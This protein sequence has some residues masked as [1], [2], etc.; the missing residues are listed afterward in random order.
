MKQKLQL[1]KAMR[2]DWLMQKKIGGFAIVFFLLF[3]LSGYSQLATESFE[4]G[5]PSS[6]SLFQNSFGTTSWSSSSDGYQGG[7]AAVVNPASENIG[8][9]NT[10]EYY[11]VTPSVAVPANGEIRFFTKQG[12]AS[13]NGTVYQLRL[14]TAS[15]P[16][17]DGFSVVLQTWTEDDLNTISPTEY[18]EKVVVIPS[19]IPV[20]LNVYIAF[21]AVNNQS[22]NDPSGDSWFIDDVRVIE[23]CPSIASYDV[24]FANTTLNSTDVNWVNPSAT[25]FEI[26][27]VP[28]GDAPAQNGTLVS[29]P[30]YSFSSLPPGTS[31]DVYIKSICNSSFSSGW[32]GPFSFKTL[33]L[34]D[35]CDAPVLIPDLSSP[36]VTTDNLN[37][38][39]TNAV[40]LSTPGS[41]CTTL[42]SNY[43]NGGKAF[44]SFTPT[45]TG[46]VKITMTPT[47]EFSYSGLF[48]YEGCANVGVTCVG[49]VA[50]AANAPRIINLEVTAGTNYI[51]LVSSNYD[52]SASV[53]YTLKVE[54]ASCPIPFDVDVSSILQTSAKLS[55]ANI[56]NYATSWE[57]AVQADG[58]GVPSGSGIAA[59]SNTNVSVATTLGG[60]PL[61]AGTSYEVYVR[62]NCGLGFT[63]WSAGYH[64]TT[65]CNVFSTPY[66]E[67]FNTGTS[68]TPVACWNVIDK[69]N[70][71]TVWSYRLDGEPSI[72]TGDT[73]GNN[74]DF[75]ISPQIDLSGE[76]KRLRF[77]YRGDNNVF[78]VVLS[79]TGIGA[80][81]FTTVLLPVNTYS[82]NFEYVEKI[83]NIPATITG[84][85]NIAWYVSPNT[86]ETGFRLTLDD[87]YIE[88]KPACSDPLSPTAANITTTTAELSWEK[89]DIETQ[90]DVAIQPL[91]TGLPTGNGIPADSNPFTATNLIPATRYEYYVRAH[92]SSTQYSNWVGPFNFTTLCASFET[93]FYESFNDVDSDTKKFC[94]SINNANEDD[95]KWQMNEEYPS[96]QSAGF[97]FPTSSYDDWLISPAINVVGSKALKFKYRS[98]FSFFATTSRFG[99]EVLISTTDTNPSSFTVLSPL[100][101]FTN[102]DFLEKTLYFTGN[103]PIYIAFR[104]PPQFSVAGGTSI[105]QIDDVRIEDMPACPNPT[106]L[107]AKNITQNTA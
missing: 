40:Y 16:D 95:A 62:A 11:L 94:W 56:G 81:D 18:E 35:T 28:A 77:K 46:V 23:T 2:F 66:F 1:T 3:S 89:G 4:S 84:N 32:A 87:V 63:D 98:A 82:T 106:D 10:A 30:T 34:G 100:M 101:E 68:T 38:Y 67:D 104:V 64:F 9:G 70:D 71:G 29:A 65:Q 92:C 50:N 26:Q 54:S 83:V 45:T 57:Y 79:T 19:S 103:G 33:K 25:D 60:S 61:F 41:S 37:N 13:N 21:V 43:A 49:G 93:P 15:Q 39:N 58:T 31:Y 90:W 53:P 85:V 51:I 7:K 5:I 72:Y 102:T 76:P 69:N 96:I 14:S 20:G 36:F 24:S 17:I 74:N 12:N 48:V 8:S 42:T 47:E 91:G 73:N 97:F 86:N 75:F 55:W 107:V 59:T 44:Y 105:L 27:R 99:V 80:N 78:S 52:S 88:D 22:G 6:W